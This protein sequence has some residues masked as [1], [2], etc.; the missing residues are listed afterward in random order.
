[1]TIYHM[2]KHT[3]LKSENKAQNCQSAGTRTENGI[4]SPVLFLSFLRAQRPFPKDM[5]FAIYSDVKLKG[6]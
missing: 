4:T 5:F 3:L 1:M 6:F 2:I